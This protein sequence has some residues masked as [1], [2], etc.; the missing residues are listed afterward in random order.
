MVAAKVS[1]GSWPTQFDE[2]NTMFLE[3]QIGNSLCAFHF[4]RNVLEA[5][6][7]F[8][9]TLHDSTIGKPA[10]FIVKIPSNLPIPLLS[11]PPTIVP[12]LELSHR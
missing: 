2:L 12:L 3:M 4:I 9:S 5:I 1:F 8:P 11:I 6:N 10:F 7:N